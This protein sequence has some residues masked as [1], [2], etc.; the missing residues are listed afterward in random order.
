[1]KLSYRGITYNYNSA[2]ATDLGYRAATLRHNQKARVANL[3]ALLTYRGEVYGV[4]AGTQATPE[5]KEVSAT[6][7]YRGTTYQVQPTAQP[8]PAAVAATTPVV[9]SSIEARARALN[10]D[11]HRVTKNRQQLVL[12]RFAS[13]AGLTDS[14]ANYWNHIQGKI[15]P[16][17]WA[18]FDRSHVA[19]S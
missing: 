6:L 16:S 5:V 4:Q 11:H 3:S 10:S 9:A 8:V 17:F 18:T 7:T 15:H 12:S 19:L 1:M 13:E 2:P 14:V